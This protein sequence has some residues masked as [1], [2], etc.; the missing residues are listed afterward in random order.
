[1]STIDP[2]EPTSLTEEDPTLSESKPT[3]EEG[4]N[5]KAADT[6]EP[7]DGGNDKDVKEEEETQ[8]VSPQGKEK[9]ESKNEHNDAT[10]L[11]PQEPKDN[12]DADKDNDDDEK[13]KEKEKEEE[14]DDAKDESDKK[15]KEKPTGSLPKR[16]L[17][18]ARTAY[19]IFTDERRP[20]IQA[21]VRSW[22]IFKVF[23]DSKQSTTSMCVVFLVSLFLSFFE[24]SGTNDFL[25]F[26]L[27]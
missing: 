18:R 17:K 6:T 16:P 2:A 23:P 4:N 10:E 1:M 13:K 20:E 12:N 7:K 3:D 15:N 9:E 11:D 22:R 8:P 24:N 14:V 25:A 5:D 26:S 27:I 19:F 21:Q